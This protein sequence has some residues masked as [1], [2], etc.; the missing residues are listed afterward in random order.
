MIQS[1]TFKPIYTSYPYAAGPEQN[2]VIIGLALN[3]KAARAVK[4]IQPMIHFLIILGHSLHISQI[5]RFNLPASKSHALASAG[6]IFLDTFSGLLWVP[7]V[8]SYRVLGS[9]YSNS[10]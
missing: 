3:M 1:V 8:H 9:R 2:S 4:R 6:T 10:S 5:C 7:L